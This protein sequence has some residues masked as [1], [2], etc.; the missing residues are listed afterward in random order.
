M[1]MA[2]CSGQN[3]SSVVESSTAGTTEATSSVSDSSAEETESK[4]ETSVPE[5]EATSS[6]ET[7]TTSA[8]ETEATSAP[9]TE[10]T[11]APETEATKAP[12][13][14]A[15]KAPETE[16]TKK[17]ETEATKKPE[18]EAT[19]K[20]ETEATKKP[21]TTTTTT[22]APETEAPASKKYI[23]LT[24]DDGPNTTTTNQVLDLLEKYD[25]KATFFL[26]GDN[27]NDESAKAVK[28]AFDMGCEIGNHSKS[29][30]YM[31]K[32]TADEIKAEVQYVSDKIFE[33]TGQREKYFRPPYIA[34][35]DL[36]FNTIDL[37][38]INGKG[39]NDW[40][41]NV[42]VDKRILML[43][44]RLTGD[45]VIILLH[46]AQGNDKT[47]EALEAYIPYLIEQG[48]ELVTL[49]ELFEI[50][51]ASTDGSDNKIYSKVPQDSQW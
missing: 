3:V 2:G 35:N 42:S 5:T 32:M 39:C 25:A 43:E 17:P 23:A 29:H 27:I 20:P 16:A 28:R 7:E 48:Y 51:G 11:K 21:E 22:K 6:P 30:N 8:P 14:E 44:R 18:T 47:V 10:A 34:V 37:T 33:I 50:K 24:F 19:K 1:L 45:G 41:D 40:D 13:T 49:S 26:I 12:E 31:D 15:T 4:Q 36:M 9:E 38:F 46:D